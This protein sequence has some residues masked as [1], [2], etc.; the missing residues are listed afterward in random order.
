MLGG[1]TIFDKYYHKTEI[2]SV[3]ISKTKQI[4]DI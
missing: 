4:L 3:E 2:I 1:D